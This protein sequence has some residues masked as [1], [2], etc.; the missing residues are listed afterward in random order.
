MRRLSVKFPV[1]RASI[2]A[3]ERGGRRCDHHRPFR[4]RRQS[5]MRQL[6]S[7]TT[8]HQRNTNTTTLFQYN[9]SPTQY[10][11]Y[12]TNPVQHITNAIPTLQHLS[13]T[14]HHQCNTNK[15]TLIQYYISPT[16]YQH[17]STN[18]EQ[19]I[20]NAITKKEPIEKNRQNAIP[21]Q[22]HYN[23]AQHIANSKKTQQH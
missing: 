11:H 21:T 9:T 17:N 10:Q 13:S 12:N 20:I 5:Q 14:T 19:H 4:S 23:T 18:T 3:D 16:Q 7:S 22:Q 2:A 6:T 8:H 15:T 1:G